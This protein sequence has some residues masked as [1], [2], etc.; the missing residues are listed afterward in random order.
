MGMGVQSGGASG[1]PQQTQMAMQGGAPQGL[2]SL[3]PQGGKGAGLP[4]QMPPGEQQFYDQLQAVAAR[5]MPAAGTPGMPLS[6]APALGAGPGQ[7]TPEMLNAMRQFQNQTQP[8]QMMPSGMPMSGSAG[9]G[10]G[11][12]APMPRPQMP[13]LGKGA[14][15]SGTRPTAPQT[16]AQPRPVRTP[17]PVMRDNP[18]RR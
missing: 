4:P 15:L 10:A 3:M 17:A 8:A 9:K 2:M 13:S 7:P 5:Q 12:G 11:M 18:G 6:G 16:V 14:G 1:M